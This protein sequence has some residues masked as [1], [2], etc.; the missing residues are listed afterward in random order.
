MSGEGF[1]RSEGAFEAFNRCGLLYGH[2][3]DVS[4]DTATEDQRKPHEA[5]RH[6]PD[7]KNGQPQSGSPAYVARVQTPARTRHGGDG[8]D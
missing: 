6:P 7:D 8:G 2:V 1:E 4:R 3:I 5:G